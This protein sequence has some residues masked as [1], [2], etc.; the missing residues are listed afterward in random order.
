MSVKSAKILIVD[1]DPEI[2]KLVKFILKDTSYNFFS[3]Q[4]GKLALTE[5]ERQNYDLLLVDR[6]MPRMDGLS[7]IKVVKNDLKLDVP[8]I[9]MSAHDQEDKSLNEL[10]DLIYD[11]VPKPFTA[12][13][14][15]LIIRNALQYQSLNN[16]YVS[17]IKSVIT[18]E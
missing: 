6:L 8:V 18:D 11:I 3:A 17:L 5:L 12:L 1:D 13:R 4:N 14:L 2:I 9:L 10:A 15:K 7:F 16:K